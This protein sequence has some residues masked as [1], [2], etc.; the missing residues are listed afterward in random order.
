MAKPLSIKSIYYSTASGAVASGRHV[1]DGIAQTLKTPDA[2]SN[3]YQTVVNGLEPTGFNI[4]DS[5]FLQRFRVFDPQNIFET[6]QF[7]NTN[8]GV[9]LSDFNVVEPTNYLNIN[10]SIIKM[11]EWVDVNL[12][13]PIEQGT[14]T[15]AVPK[16]TA[17][18]VTTYYN[19]PPEYVGVVEAY[20]MYEIEWVHTLPMIT[21]QPL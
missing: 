14:T 5:V 19:A 16:I 13:F 10:A 9:S 18:S 17:P 20:L 21:A 11:N 2:W 15:F 8:I 4:N 1:L 3:W 7:Q 12:F 6:A